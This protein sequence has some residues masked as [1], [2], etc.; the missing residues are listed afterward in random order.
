MTPSA[1]EYLRSLTA[2]EKAALAEKCGISRFY[3]NNLIY[4][5]KSP[6]PLLA[7]RIEDATSGRV[8]RRQ[9]LPAV[10]WDLLQGSNAISRR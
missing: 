7:C 6:S 10:D 5:K 3:L 1:K 9:L 2:T 8:T 4:T